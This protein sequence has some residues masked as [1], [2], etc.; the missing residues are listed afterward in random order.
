MISDGDVILT[1]MIINVAQQHY[2]NARYFGHFIVNKE[3]SG[4]KKII[5][6]DEDFECVKYSK[7]V[8]DRIQEG[9]L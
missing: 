6:M 3:D 9:E 8:I 5:Y 7:E 2:P 1:N 4:R